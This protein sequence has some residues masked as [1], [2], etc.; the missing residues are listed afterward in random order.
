VDYDI[1]GDTKWYIKLMDCSTTDGTALSTC[2]DSALS[3]LQKEACEGSTASGGDAGYAASTSYPCA[4]GSAVCATGEACTSSSNTC[5]KVCY[6]TAPTNGDLGD[7][8]AT[9]VSGDTCQPACDSG[10]TLVPR[11]DTTMSCTVGVLSAPTCDP[12]PCDGTQNLPSNA[13]VGDC[14]ADLASGNTCTPTCASGYALSCLSSCALGEITHGTCDEPTVTV[15]EQARDADTFTIVFD[16]PTAECSAS[17]LYEVKPLAGRLKS[18]SSVPLAGVAMVSVAA[19][20]AFMA[21]RM[22]QGIPPVDAD[23]VEAH[24]DEQGEA[25][26]C[27][28]ARALLLSGAL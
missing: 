4:C 22:K 18:V 1:T 14:T 10:Y 15:N 2:D 13:A 19:V 12:D 16:P 28:E 23:D 25:E 11:A 5:E 26:V 9:L 8:D 17:R 6:P 27:N 3:A 21:S 20:A 7:C 24:E